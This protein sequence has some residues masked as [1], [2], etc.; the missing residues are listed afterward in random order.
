MANQSL[1][2]H[3][4]PPGWK[5]AQLGS[6]CNVVNGSGFPTRYQGHTSLTFPLVKVSDMNA[7]DNGI[8][9]KSAANTVDDVI[10]AAMRAR[11]CP[12]GTVIF[13][14][15][16]GAVYTNKKRILGTPSA[17]DN[18]VMGLIPTGVLS[19]WLFLCLQQI[20]LASLAN[21][22]ALPSIKASVVKGIGIPLP[23]LPEQK[24]IVAILNE[25]M[26]A[27][28]RAKKAAEEQRE[29]ALALR[30][31]MVKQSFRRYFEEPRAGY[32]HA[33]LAEVC[34]IVTG[35]TPSKSYPKFY[36][37]SIPWVN[38][39]HLG[40]SKYVS[41][42]DEYLTSEGLRSARLVPMGTVMLT[43]ISGSR[44]NIGKAAIAQQPLTT[45][46]QINSVIP[47]THVQSEFLYYHL[48]AIKHNLEELAAS[49]NQ[50]IVNKSK[51]SMI[52]I[53]V[54]PLEIQRRISSEIN[55]RLET[56]DTV[57]KSVSQ[58]LESLNSLPSALL[59]RAFSGEV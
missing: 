54:P 31:A 26:A 53:Q 21:I 56:R 41:D 48:L 45:N 20:E 29:A 51:L 43:C 25:Q 36:G 14:K 2:S 23:P 59:R 12:E 5:W 49:T 34:T 10:L 38:P 40:S 16:G 22:Q 7:P 18:N 55:M 58:G 6:V 47:G 28:A 35:N 19:G 44:N 30:E 57:E 33:K 27:V 37:G 4:L 42:S 46:Q 52:E 39:S 13:P 24:R 1:H 50:N 32:P 3:Y 9:I 11:V 8:F 17:F 15:V